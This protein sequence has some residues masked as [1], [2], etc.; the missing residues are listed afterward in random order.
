VGSR[1]EPCEERRESHGN[2]NTI[3]ELSSV[4]FHALE[5]GASYDTYIEDAERE[6]DE[7]LVDFFTRVRDE[8]SMLTCR[9]L[10]DEARQE[11]SSTVPIYDVIYDVTEPYVLNP[12]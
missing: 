3:Y 10:G 7:E 8:D 1:A 12:I 9:K 5:G 6:V 4:L 11:G 2:P